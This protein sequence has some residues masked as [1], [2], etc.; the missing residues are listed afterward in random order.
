MRLLNPF[1]VKVE[2][3]IGCPPYSAYFVVSAA[4]NIADAFDAAAPSTPYLDK[5][6]LSMSR[7]SSHSAAGVDD[8]DRMLDR[9]SSMQ[10][11]HMSPDELRFDHSL[12]SNEWA[13]NLQNQKGAFSVASVT[14][15]SN[16]SAKNIKASNGYIQ[17]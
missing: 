17:Q 10:Q 12:D 14:R 5:I 9:P 2:L 3:L 11:Q 13:E 7:S 1:V 8:S 6:E 15:K 16:K 4:L